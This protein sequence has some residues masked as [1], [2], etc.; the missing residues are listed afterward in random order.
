MAGGVKNVLKADVVKQRFDRT[1]FHHSQ[2]MNVMNI[3][4]M[5]AVLENCL[6]TSAFGTAFTPLHYPKQ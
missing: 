4:N 2:T 3:M 5:T 6:M 1:P